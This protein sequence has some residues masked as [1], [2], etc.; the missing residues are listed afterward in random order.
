MIANNIITN[1][2]VHLHPDDSVSQALTIMHINYVK[3]LPVVK[4]N[5]LIGI[6][7]EEELLRFNID[8]PLSTLELS[9]IGVYAKADE[10]IFEIFSKMVEHKLTSIPVVDVDQKYLG[11][12]SQEDLIRHYANSFSIREPGSLLVLEVNK[13]SYTLSEMAR[14]VEL[15]NASIICSF[16]SEI[17]NNANVLV[18]LKINRQDI[19]SIIKAFD[20]YDYQI[21]ATYAEEEIMDNLRERYD[22]LMSYLNV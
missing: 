11:L 8:D 19:Q 15:E 22:S 20:R 3:H 16:I 6:A 1:A 18:T 17:P 12:I 14:I 13:R 21:K 9:D 7:S 2:L 10:H 4:N 5:S